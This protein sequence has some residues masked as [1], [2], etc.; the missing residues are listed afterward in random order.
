MLQRL[1]PLPAL[2]VWLMAWG[3]HVAL[4]P[5]TASPWL[6]LGLPTLLGVALAAWPVWASTR[7]RAMFLAAGFPV[8]VSV[9]AIMPTSANSAASPSMGMAWLL[10]LGL[11]LLAYPVRAWRD[12][13]VYPTPANALNGLPG[14]LPLPA[15]TRILDAGCGLGHGLQ[16]LRAAY[17]AAQLNGIEWSWPFAM[18]ARWRCPWAKV[19]RG[20]MWA[21]DWSAFDVV[22]VFQ[23]P[24]SM[25]RIWAKARAEMKP[26]AWLV[27]LAF[28]IPQ[29]TPTACVGKAVRGNVHTLWLYQLKRLH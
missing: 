14:H 13:P 6:L 19:Q 1:W 17:P 28:E 20:D 4:R 21:Q 18:W 3:M 7:W 16:A 25:P 2:L 26:G 15:G 10:P 5:W 9:M 11:L 23:R 27:S 24:E 12:A 29:V 8:S 22:Y